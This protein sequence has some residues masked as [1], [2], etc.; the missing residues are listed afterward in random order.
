MT[1]ITNEAK[2]LVC[3]SLMTRI[4]IF[5]EKLAEAKENDDLPLLKDYYIRQTGLINRLEYL[6]SH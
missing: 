5:D 2:E 3:S 4:S 1:S 6:L